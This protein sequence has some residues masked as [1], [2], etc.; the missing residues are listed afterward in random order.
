MKED[1]EL[2]MRAGEERAIK[3]HDRVNVVL[4]AVERLNGRMDK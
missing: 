2:I 4:G 1:R 3:I